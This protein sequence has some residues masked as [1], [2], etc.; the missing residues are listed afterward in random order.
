M[1]SGRRGDREGVQEL[2]AQ[3]SVGHEEQHVGDSTLSLVLNP[4]GDALL[5]GPIASALGLPSDRARELAAARLRARL[6][7]EHAQS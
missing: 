5:G 6:E 7:A 1:R 4:L 3:R 2:V